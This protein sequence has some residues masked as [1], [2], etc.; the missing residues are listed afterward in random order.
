MIRTENQKNKMTE[1][2]NIQGKVE[3][4]PSLEERKERLLA[5]HGEIEQA[6]FA[7]R[8]DIE[9]GI[10]EAKNDPLGWQVSFFDPAITTQEEV[11]DINNLGKDIKPILEIDW[12]PEKKNYDGKTTPSAFV[13]NES[14][15]MPSVVLE[16]YPTHANVNEVDNIEWTEMHVRMDDIAR[17]SIGTIRRNP[18]AKSDVNVGDNVLANNFPIENIYEGVEEAEEA[19]GRVASALR[20][21]AKRN[22]RGR[23]FTNTQNGLTKARFLSPKESRFL[24]GK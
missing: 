7:L 15:N 18:K 4:K 10:P 17:A 13:L 20:H 2:R 21:L 5:L 6:L 24:K 12:N 1:T 23:I 19:F 8:Q 9:S 3:E 14:T 11:E 16:L 22:V